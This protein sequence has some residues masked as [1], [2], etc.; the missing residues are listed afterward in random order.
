ML[1][2][3]SWHKNRK[4]KNKVICGLEQLHLGWTGPLR[5]YYYV[6][7]CNFFSELLWIVLCADMFSYF[8][9]IFFISFIRTVKLRRKA[10]STCL[11]FTMFA[12]IW[13][14]VWTSVLQ[15]LNQGLSSELKVRMM[16]MM[17]SCIFW[18]SQR[19]CISVDIPETIS[20]V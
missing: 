11:S 4:L 12:W 15:M 13:L 1:I 6:K 2:L 18:I 14:V 19:N 16:D 3:P 20:I 5:A 10:P 17:P 8:H 7:L 9:I